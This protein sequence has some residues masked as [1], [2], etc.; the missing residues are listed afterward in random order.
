MPK[1]L[2][3]GSMIKMPGVP[4]EDENKSYS[5]KTLEQMYP[6]TPP[7]DT[8]SEAIGARQ[9]Y[10]NQKTM[11]ENQVPATLPATPETDIEAY[12]RLSR[13]ASEAGP[14]EQDVLMAGVRRSLAETRAAGIPYLEKA[15]ETA[16]YKPD[17]SKMAEAAKIGLGR[18][19]AVLTAKEQAQKR[20]EGLAEG[21]RKR[22]LF[23]GEMKE[24]ETKSAEADARMQALKLEADAAS[25]AAS[26]DIEKFM[27]VYGKKFGVTLPDNVTKGELSDYYT[28]G[29]KGAFGVAEAKER[30]K[31]KTEPSGIQTEREERLKNKELNTMITTLRNQYTKEADG[32]R[33]GLEAAEK[34]EQFADSKNWALLAAVGPQLAKGI[35]GDVGA[36]SNK[37]IQRY[38]ANPELLTRYKDMILR[39]LNGE[40]SDATAQE[41]KDAA[42]IVKGLLKDKLAKKQ[43]KYRKIL[44]KN[45]LYTNLGGDEEYA[46][47]QLFGGEI[48]GA[49]S[50]KTEQPPTAPTKRRKATSAEELP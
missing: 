11:D 37:D 15:A 29:I 34:I 49:G 41:Y 17:Y 19:D 13:E 20:L 32:S 48:Y 27:D 9:D 28:Q 50:V 46:N 2:Y 36:L 39:A 40:I 12:Q 38:D 16:F 44:T 26:T 4:D 35:G 42:K 47:E 22:A 23:P 10:T 21:A 5:Q 7:L 3:P 25:P 24:Q 6:A 14:T 1:S 33:K 43:D 31:L 18:P 8:T 30:A 45:K